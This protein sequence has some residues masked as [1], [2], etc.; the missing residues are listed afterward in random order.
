[1]TITAQ[2]PTT[3]TRLPRLDGQVLTPGIPGYDAARSVW[4]GAV[5]RRPALII[6]CASV[7][8]VIAAVR[9]ARAS[10]LEIGVRCG[11]HN[12]AGLAVPQGGLMIDLTGLNRIEVDP[13]AMRAR[14]QG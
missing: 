9:A 8:D 4:N 5:D 6:R 1:M 10:D 7:D 11:G 2:S 3:T 13:V 12:I 14:V